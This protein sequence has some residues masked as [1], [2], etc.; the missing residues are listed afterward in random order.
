MGACGAIVGR[1]TVRWSE[2]RQGAHRDGRGGRIAVR[3]RFLF[4]YFRPKI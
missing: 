4:A 3:L 2:G 1:A